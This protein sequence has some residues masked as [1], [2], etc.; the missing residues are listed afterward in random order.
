[1]KDNSDMVFVGDGFVDG[2]QGIGKRFGMAKVF[3]NGL[4]A[5]LHIYELKTKSGLTSSR[6]LRKIVL[7]TIPNITDIVTINV[8]MKDRF[9]KCAGHVADNKLVLLIPQVIF[10]VR[11]ESRGGGGGFLISG[12]KGDSGRRLRIRAIDKFPETMANKERFYLTKPNKIVGVGEFDEVR[13]VGAR[14]RQ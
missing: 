13:G 2:G 5:F 11:F 10:V 1:M 9:S 3:I 7:E 8:E 6:R 4:R 12:G 14:K